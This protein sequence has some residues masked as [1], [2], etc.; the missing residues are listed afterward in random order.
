MK[1]SGVAELKARAHQLNKGGSSTCVFLFIHVHTT[2]I[3]EFEPEHF[4]LSAYPIFRPRSWRAKKCLAIKLQWILANHPWIA[5]LSENVVSELSTPKLRFWP[6]N[7]WKSRNRKVV[8]EAMSKSP[9]L[10]IQY[11]KN[12]GVRTPG[13]LDHDWSFRQWAFCPASDGLE[14]RALLKCF[15]MFYVV[16]ID[17]DGH[18]L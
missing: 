8:G 9:L 12:A 11:Q 1:F 6:D 5:L 2:L 15:L 3:Y 18:S 14:T 7:G 4:A 16:K 13:Q 17:E 10:E